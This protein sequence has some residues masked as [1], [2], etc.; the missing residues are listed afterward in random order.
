M[1]RLSIGTFQLQNS[2]VVG[3]LTL[4]LWPPPI[5]FV[6]FR[7]PCP[8][9]PAGPNPCATVLTLPSNGPV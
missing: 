8:G 1:H 7:Q 3:D 2:V 5:R 9:A 4:D 6:R